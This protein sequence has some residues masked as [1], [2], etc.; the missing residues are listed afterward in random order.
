MHS[1]HP[2][3]FPGRAKVVLVGAG[4]SGSALFNRLVNLHLALPAFG[5]RGLS[6]VVADPDVV[7]ESNL[8]RQ[9]FFYADI[10]QNKATVIVNRAN[11]AYGLDWR[12]HPHALTAEGFK[13]QHIDILVECVDSRWSRAEV[14]AFLN[15]S[16]SVLYH[17][18]LG[19]GHRSGQVVLGQPRNR[20]NGPRRRLP[21]AYELYPELTDPTLPEDDEPS[22]GTAEAL[23]KQDLFINDALAGAAANLLWKLLVDRELANH[24]VFL[25]L[26]N[27]QQTPMAVDP[28]RWR[29]VRRRNRRAQMR[30]ALG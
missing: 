8:V 18:S 10:G 28:K 25:N 5:H 17:L 29:R 22:C 7:S 24:G 14:A 23:K 9:R 6:V 13:N 12:A 21:T 30:K 11:L 16:P 2:R 20:S 27:D 3:L 4:G 19:N 1:A 15:E 26:E